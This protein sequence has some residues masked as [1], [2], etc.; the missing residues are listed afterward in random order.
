M[1]K[2]GIIRENSKKPITEIT[3]KAI[4]SV[5]KVSISGYTDEHCSMIQ[6]Q[7]KELLEY[8]RKNNSSNEVAFVFDS[9][10]GNRKEY[11]GSD[12]KIDCG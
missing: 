3:D 2:S 9:S 10:L 4:E 8:S 1:Q 6:E 7:H 11:M 12:D 5:P